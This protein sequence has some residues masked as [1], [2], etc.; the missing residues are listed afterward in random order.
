MPRSTFGLFA[1]A[2]PNVSRL[3]SGKRNTP[4]LIKVR[5]PESEVFYSPDMDFHPNNNILGR[6]I[7]RLSS[8]QHPSKAHGTSLIGSTNVEGR[9]TLDVVSHARNFLLVKEDKG[10]TDP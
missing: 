2:Q 6:F 3:K 1:C 10:P 5:L 8:V 9:W 4:K 7:M